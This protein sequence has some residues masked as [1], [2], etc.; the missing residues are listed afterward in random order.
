MR[1]NSL[2]FSPLGAGRL[3]EPA[4]PRPLPAAAPGRTARR[5]SLLHVSAAALALGGGLAC[6][7]GEPRAELDT[8]PLPQV[9]AG[10]EGQIYDPC[11]VLRADCRLGV[12]SAVRCLRQQPGGV[13]PP[14]RAIS[15]QAFEAELLSNPAEEITG[16]GGQVSMG[17]PPEES[18]EEVVA[19]ERQEA[20][21][22][23]L[24]RLGLSNPGTVGQAEESSV[25]LDRATIAGY[26]VPRVGITLIDTRESYGRQTRLLAHE[27]VHAL[28]DQTGSLS[29]DA[30][31]T[32]DE[33]LA[34]RS[35]IEGE[36]E[37][38]ETYFSAAMWR[39]SGD[40]DFEYLFT[41]WVE[42]AQADL[43]QFPALPASLR[44]F[45]YSYGARFAYRVHESGGP[46]ALKAAVAT[47][48][49]STLSILR[50]EVDPER[51]ALDRLEGYELPEEL[52]ALP[53]R[54][55]DRL[56]PWI[57]KKLLE[58][59]AA[60]AAALSLA[61]PWQGDRLSVFGRSAESYSGVWT[62]SL[63]G[64]EGATEL[65][66]ALRAQEEIQLDGLWRNG[67][68]VTLWV[69]NDAGEPAAWEDAVSE[70]LAP[71]P[72]APDGSPQPMAGSTEK[73]RQPTTDPRSPA[74]GSLTPVLI[75][76]L[77]SERLP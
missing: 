7:Q 25:E 58:A 30:P 11:N 44:Y 24:V 56:G 36:A 28:Q 42:E 57:L 9:V 18:A 49:R 2:G 34:S 8:R 72:A 76:L 35:I 55:A 3:A 77:G 15:T 46:E 59:F 64:E 54:G 66:E 43:D 65:Y 1:A 75:R 50:G 20:T 41:S 52:A 70:G 16:G 13:M 71:A 5:A 45:P 37:L 17:D 68:Y 38:L 69:G 51:V 12:F 39:A 29:V 73:S 74:R 26:Y 47:P 40:I 19:R 33:F 27:L 21:R 22:E 61:E 62:L 31:P 67:R 48:P 53:L 4:R 23:V 14:V 63:G 10:C 6:G 60:P 32:Y